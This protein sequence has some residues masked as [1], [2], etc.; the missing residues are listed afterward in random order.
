M[1]SQQ[2]GIMG[3]AT[4]ARAAAAQPPHGW[5]ALPPEGLFVVV[6]KQGKEVGRLRFRNAMIRFGRNHDV[7]E[8][9]QDHLSISRVHAALYWHGADER[10]YI[11]DLGSGAWCPPLAVPNTA[12]RATMLSIQVLAHCLPPATPC[13]CQIHSPFGPML[14][15]N[16]Q[17][18]T[19]RSFSTTLVCK[20][21]GMVLAVVTTLL[22]RLSQNTPPV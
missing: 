8:A 10:P 9:P 2:A 6:T 7:C 21:T 14:F 20:Q 3:A 5:T 22:L 17:Q 11:E 15:H 18:R 1:A 13:F 19:A 12:L 16:V 4:S